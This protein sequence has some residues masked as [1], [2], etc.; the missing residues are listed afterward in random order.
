MSLSLSL[1]KMSGED[2][3]SFNPRHPKKGKGN[4]SCVS[5]FVAGFLHTLI[6]SIVLSN[7]TAKLNSTQVDAMH[8]T[9]IAIINGLPLS[10]Q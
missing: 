3:M 7:P 10:A 8:V 5:P 1:E 9:L 4:S 6:T 2:R